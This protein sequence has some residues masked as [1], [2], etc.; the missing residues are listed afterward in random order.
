MA[1]NIYQIYNS[2]DN[3]LIHETTELSFIHEGLSNGSEYCYY[4]SV[5]YEEGESD[6]SESVCAIPNEIS[7]L[8]YSLSFDGIPMYQFLI[9]AQT[10]SL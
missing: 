3:T 5:Q 7:E 6:P 2:L 9:G 4:I 10:I 1:F 8:N